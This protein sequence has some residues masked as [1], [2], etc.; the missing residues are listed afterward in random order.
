MTDCNDPAR[1]EDRPQDGP[2]SRD[3]APAGPQTITGTFRRVRRGPSVRFQ[4]GKE[5]PV[6]KPATDLPRAEPRPPRVAIMLALA[7]KLQRLLD[8]GQVASQAEIARMLDVTPARVTQLLD[9]TLLAP[10]IQEA[11]LSKEATDSWPTAER[12]VRR[13]LST[14]DWTFQRSAWPAQSERSRRLTTSRP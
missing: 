9:L 2:E 4:K 14:M 5:P 11:I 8:D 10:D 7:H 12:H 3:D 6:G 1:R 13:L